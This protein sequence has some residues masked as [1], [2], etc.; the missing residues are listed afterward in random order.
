[1]HGNLDEYT[2]TSGDFEN[3]LQGLRLWFWGT[4]KHCFVCTT[5][6]NSV[7]ELKELHLHETRKSLSNYSSSIYSMAE[8]EKSIKFSLEDEILE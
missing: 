3:T 1:M 2:P 6:R 5:I 4:I 8:V 7:V